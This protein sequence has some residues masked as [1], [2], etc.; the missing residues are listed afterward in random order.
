MVHLISSA[1]KS[2]TGSSAASKCSHAKRTAWRN[3]SK[4]LLLCKTGALDYYQLDLQ[5]F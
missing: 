5:V 4:N 1:I 3:S 2:D